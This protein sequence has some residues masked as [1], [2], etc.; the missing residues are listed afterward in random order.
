MNQRPIFTSVRPLAIIS[1][2]GV[3]SNPLVMGGISLSTLY[4]PYAKVSS[5]VTA[6]VMIILFSNIPPYYRRDFVLDV[7]VNS[8][9]HIFHDRICVHR[10]PL[11]CAEQSR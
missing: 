7:C 8:E 1:L 10:H 2:V 6:I 9:V 11:R 5:L 4:F 3:I